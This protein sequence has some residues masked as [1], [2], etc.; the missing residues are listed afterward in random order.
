MLPS[1]SSETELSVFEA[2]E[3]DEFV[4]AAHNSLEKTKEII[5]AKPLI[6]NCRSPTS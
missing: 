6:L 1:F 3:I 2:E 5:E 4:G